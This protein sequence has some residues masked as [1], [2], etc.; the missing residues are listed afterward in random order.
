VDLARLPEFIQPAMG[1]KSGRATVRMET[2]V[3]YFYPEKETKV[4]IDVSFANGMIT[5]SFPHSMNGE[6]S[7]DPASGNLMFRAF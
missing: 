4:T 7:I 1:S 5:E 2:P 6:I 3:L